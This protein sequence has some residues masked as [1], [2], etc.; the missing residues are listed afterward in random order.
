MS[1]PVVGRIV[2]LEQSSAGITLHQLGLK[3]RATNDLRGAADAFEEYRRR[4]PT[5]PLLEDA[6]LSLIE[7]HLARRI[8]SDAVQEADGFLRRFP[9]SEKKN[10]VRLL[11]ANIQREWGDCSAAVPEY[12]ALAAAG[13][14]EADDAAFFAAVCARRDG[15][16]PEAQRRLGAYLQNF[17]AGRHRAEASQAVEGS[18]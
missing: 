10:Q 11:R 12:D 7:A 9:L 6:W 14:R 5:G 4:F 15:R 16:H 18:P 3:L 8:Y 17:P 13:G 1:P 2:R